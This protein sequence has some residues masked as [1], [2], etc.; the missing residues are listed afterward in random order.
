MF[1][2]NTAVY[3]FKY[4]STTTYRHVHSEPEKNVNFIFDYNF[5]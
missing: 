5:G 3:A 2:D 1:T 4:T